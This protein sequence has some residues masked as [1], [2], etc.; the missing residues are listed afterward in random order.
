[1]EIKLN[2]YFSFLEVD[3]LIQF[4]LLL[5]SNVNMFQLRILQTNLFAFIFQS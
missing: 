3:S 1:M 2:F 5:L 4:Y